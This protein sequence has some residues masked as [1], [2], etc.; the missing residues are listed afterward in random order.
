LTSKKGALR[1]LETSVT[2]Y[3]STTRNIPEDMIHYYIYFRKPKNSIVN[4]M[5]QCI[6][7]IHAKKMYGGVKV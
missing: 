3:K 1:S 5:S 6:S 7:K 4:V 2:I